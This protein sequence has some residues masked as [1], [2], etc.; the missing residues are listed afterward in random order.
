MQT[1]QKR[2]VWIGHAEGIS[3]L[4]LLFV[5][6]PL[7]YMM[8][9]P[10]AVRITGSLHG[11]LFV[12]FVFALLNAYM[13]KHMSIKQG[14]WFFALSFIPFGTFFIERSFKAKSIL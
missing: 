13:D 3:Y 9:I 10:Q 4:V 2:L 6:M 1:S 5:A 7:K 11:V 14:I 12:L 8:N